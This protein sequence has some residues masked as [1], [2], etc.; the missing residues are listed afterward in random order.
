[1][2][3]SPVVRALAEG[4]A[5]TP[6]ERR[7]VQGCA[8]CTAAVE[9]HRS[10]HDTLH[11]PEVAPSADFSARVLAQLEELPDPFEIVAWA[12]WRCLP[13]AAA[14]VLVLGLWTALLPSVG[15]DGGA[16]LHAED[17]VLV[18]LLTGEAP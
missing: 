13:A 3:C 7:H 16:P 9:R 8:T 11:A 6:E 1:M 17:A 18:W 15:P 10:Y 12:A 2:S 5:M 14:L 4:R